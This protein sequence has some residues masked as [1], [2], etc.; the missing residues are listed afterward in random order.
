MS[1]CFLHKKE[2]GLVKAPT[3]RPTGSGYCTC[4]WPCRSSSPVSHRICGRNAEP[5]ENPPPSRPPTNPPTNP[6]STTSM[7]LSLLRAFLPFPPSLPTL[8]YHHSR[9]LLAMQCNHTAAIGPTGLWVTRAAR[10]IGRCVNEHPMQNK[11]ET[12]EKPLSPLS[13]PPPPPDTSTQT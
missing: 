13:R 6:P 10:L 9:F 4:S 11:G 12:N 3:P 1:V 5:K 2:S 8:H 7:I